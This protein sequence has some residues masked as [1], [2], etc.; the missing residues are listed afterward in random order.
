MGELSFLLKWKTEI[1]L[2]LPSCFSSVGVPRPE[3]GKITDTWIA[4]S[5]CSGF[6]GHISVGM[7]KEAQG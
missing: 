6:N 2:H 5:S 4:L 1:S 3:A 7:N